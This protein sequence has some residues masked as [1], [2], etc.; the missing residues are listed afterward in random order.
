MI[1]QKVVYDESTDEW[2]L[3]NL[4]ISGNSL[5]MRNPGVNFDEKEMSEEMIEETKI[6]EFVKTELDAHPNVYFTYGEDGTMIRQIQEDP[7][8]KVK[9]GKKRPQSK[10]K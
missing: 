3:P 8:K 6:N 9:K 1:Q 4:D 2:V 7:T 5:R 10:K